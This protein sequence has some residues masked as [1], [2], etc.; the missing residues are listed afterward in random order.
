MNFNIIGGGLC[1]SM[2]AKEFQNN[3]LKFNLF[4][5]NEK[6][7]ASK[8][9]ENLFS[10]TWL[11]GAQYLTDSIKFLDDN[12]K[13][14]TKNFK[15]NKSTQNVYHVPID[16]ILWKDVINKKVTKLT[17]EGV[18]TNSEFYHGINIICAGY[19]TKDFINIE[20]FNA[21]TGHGLLFEPNENNLK[22]DEVMRHYRPFIHEKIMKWHDGR[23]WYGDSTTIHHDKYI[24]NTDHYIQETLKRAAKIGLSGKYQ[25][26]YGA[27]PF[28]NN[29]QK[30]LGLYKRINSN[31]FVLT[32]G[33]KD[34]MVIYPYL[35]K[36]LMKDLNGIK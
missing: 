14:V 21:L 26:Y 20:K 13:V 11:K 3:S 16:R 12:Y 22:L 15:T 10:P 23:I 8:I 27:R 32:G 31:T 18:Y 2:V 19:Y 29:S 7:A 6:F 36:Q 17:N 25:I 33:W 35:V 30:K 24:S 5:S 4:E 28:V 9:S 1:G 34:G